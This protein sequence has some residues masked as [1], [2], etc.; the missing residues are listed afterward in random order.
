MVTQLPTF[1][2]LHRTETRIG[3]IWFGVLYLF[4]IEEN[5]NIEIRKSVGF[6][7]YQSE[8]VDSLRVSPKSRTLR[9]RAALG[10]T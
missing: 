1:V 5:Q 4:D 2:A 8:P 10:P 3:D 9:E 7:C 6:F